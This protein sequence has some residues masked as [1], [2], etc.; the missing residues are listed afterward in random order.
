[1]RAR[2]PV[3]PFIRG[4]EHTA[5]VMADVI[6]ALLPCIFMSWLAYG[7]MPLMV[8][9]A[10]VGSALAAEF[11]FSLLYTGQ[12]ASLSDGSAIV[13]G[14]L[15]SLTLAPFTPLYAAAFGGAMAVVFGKLLWG[16]LGRNVFNPALVGRECMTVFFPLVMASGSIWHHAEAVNMGSLPLFGEVFLDGLFF[17]PSGAIGEYSVFFLVLG[18]IYLLARRRISWHIP[19]GFCVALACFALFPRSY[20]LRF[21]LGGV[22]LGAVYMAT[23]MP[24]SAST[25]WGK[26]YAGIMTGMVAAICLIYEVQFEYMSYAILLMNAFVRPVNWVFRPRAWGTAL[27]FSRRFWQGVLLTGGILAACFGLIGLHHL[28]MVKYLVLAYLAFCLARFMAA[29]IKQWQRQK[30]AGER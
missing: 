2:M 17:R 20:P 13:T 30:T 19:L 15:L 10:A 26:L 28:D 9:L 14:V 11:F 4:A 3:S 27:G 22:L 16:G 18:G 7:H 25:P 8:L 12:A 29:Q 21:S 6:I 23:D 5:C 1:M 24:T